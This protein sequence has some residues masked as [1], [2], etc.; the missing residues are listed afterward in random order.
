[1]Q[2]FKIKNLFLGL[3]LLFSC[4][5]FAA[6]DDPVTFND[7]DEVVSIIAPAVYDAS[8]GEIEVHSLGYSYCLDKELDL[9]SCYS[10]DFTGNY[11]LQTNRD[12][13]DPVL[14]IGDITY[15]NGSAISKVNVK[16]NPPKWDNSFELY[17]SYLQRTR[18][19]LYG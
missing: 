5:T 13:G 18:Y 16:T 1:M 8:T 17:H 2:P 14:I 15:R 19:G 3:C 10:I 11:T 7:Q 9:I 4:L 6:P 12:T